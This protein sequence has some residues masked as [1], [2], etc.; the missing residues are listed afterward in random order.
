MDL[1]FD[2]PAIDL[3]SYEDDDH[4]PVYYWQE[5]EPQLSDDYAPQP[6]FFC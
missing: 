1:I 6:A 5:D 3:L 2:S 4:A